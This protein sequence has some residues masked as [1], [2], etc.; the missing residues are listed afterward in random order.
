TLRAVDERNEVVANFE[1]DQL[2][3]QHLFDALAL[4]RLLLLAWTELLVA[5]PRGAR[6]RG[7]SEVLRRCRARGHDERA[8]EREERHHRHARQEADERER[9]RGDLQH[10][11]A[12]R[13]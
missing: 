9:A 6:C 7:P 1:F 12:L 3:G 2:D 10:A 13:E 4:R 5:C 8:T 11:L